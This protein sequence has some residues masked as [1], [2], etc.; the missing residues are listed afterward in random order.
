MKK[1]NLRF[2]A[3]G[4]AVNRMLIEV[5]G[6]AWMRRYEEMTPNNFGA[7]LELMMV[8]MLVSVATADG[9]PLITSEIARQLKMPR[10]NV[11][12]HLERLA[13]QGVIRLERRRYVSNFDG[14]DELMQSRAFVDE[15]TGVVARCLAE[16]TRL[17][18]LLN[19]QMKP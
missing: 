6:L 19:D 1:D 12:R 15:V 8:S 18:P 10:S 17:R 11:V 2:A 7:A 3:F 13:E 5:C 4:V 14:L 16:L 9:T